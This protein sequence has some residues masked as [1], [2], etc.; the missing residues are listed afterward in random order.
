MAALFDVGDRE[1]IVTSSQRGEEGGLAGGFGVTERLMMMMMGRSVD[2]AHGTLMVDEADLKGSGIEAHIVK[3][4][5]SGYTRGVAVIRM[6][7]TKEPEF[8]QPF[9]PKVIATRTEFKDAALES[10]CLDIRMKQASAREM[11]EVD[12]VDDMDVKRRAESIQNGLLFWRL[13]RGGM[14]SAE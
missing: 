13:A 5:N 11:D 9:G 14:Q 12:G 7:G 3:I 2:G 4:L 8:F 6:N 1:N 10:R